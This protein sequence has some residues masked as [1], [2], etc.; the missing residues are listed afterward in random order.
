MAKPPY[1]PDLRPMAVL[2]GMLVI[3][4]VGWIIL[5]PLILPPP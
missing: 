3:I 2:I 4:L 1:R 5:S